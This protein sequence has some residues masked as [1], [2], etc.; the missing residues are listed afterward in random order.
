VNEIDVLPSWLLV[1][2]EPTYWLAAGSRT[3][4]AVAC[5]YA[6]YQ[7]ETTTKKCNS[8]FKINEKKMAG[9]DDRK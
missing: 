9:S 2:V 8:Y 7:A 6:T 4:V 5:K 1:A 3:K